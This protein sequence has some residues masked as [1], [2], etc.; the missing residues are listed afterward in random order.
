MSKQSCYKVSYERPKYL[1][2]SSQMLNT[3]FIEA[4]IRRPVKT[5]WTLL[6]PFVP[7]APF[8]FPHSPYGFLMFPGGRERVHWEQMG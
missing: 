3:L 5:C 1:R 4:A 8:F 6:N 2:V 7:N